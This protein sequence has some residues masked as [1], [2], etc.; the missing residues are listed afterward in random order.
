MIPNIW[1]VVG[2]AFVTV[3]GFAGV[4]T[5]RLNDAQHE[6]DMRNELDRL[7]ARQDD[8]NRSRTDA[9]YKRDLAAAHAA[10]VRAATAEFITRQAGGSA[11]EL[12]CFR[13]GE[14]DA[15]LTAWSGRLAER[16]T[17]VARQAEAIAA[18]YRACQAYVLNQ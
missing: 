17:G 4:Q 9:Q 8:L 15:E 11:E 7:R 3:L 14:L 18:A 12:A 10:G 6:I 1:A 16:L 2:I 5:Y 13:A